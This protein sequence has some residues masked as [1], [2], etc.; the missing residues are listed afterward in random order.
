MDWFN[1][2]KIESLNK[3]IESLRNEL[4]ESKSNNKV[5]EFKIETLEKEIREK[6]EEI[7]EYTNE[8]DMLVVEKSNLTERISVQE[9]IIKGL[10]NEV[11]RTKEKFNELVELIN[12]YKEEM[13]SKLQEKATIETREQE[14]IIEKLNKDIRRR[15]EEVERLERKAST[16]EESYKN[17]REE[18]IRN[19]EEEN[20]RRERECE[21]KLNVLKEEI[22]ELEN[23]KQGFMLLQEIDMIDNPYNYE[24]SQEFQV[25]LD[26]IKKEQR[27]MVRDGLALVFSTTWTVANSK[28]KGEKMMKNLTKLALKSFNNECDNIIMNVRYSSMTTAQAK[29]EKSF[30]DTNKFIEVMDSK[31][32]DEY[33]ES[34]IKELQLKCGWLEKKEEEKEELRRQNE[35]L[36]E[37]EKL[38][39]EIALEEEKIEVEQQHFNNEIAN[40]EKQLES[41]NGNEDKLRKEIERLQAKIVELEERKATVLDRKMH[42]KA[43]YVYIISNPSLDGMYKIGTTRRLDPQIRV[44]ELG[45]ASLPFKF[46]VHSFIFSED[47]FGLE[48]ALH[49]A[50]ENKRVNKVNLHKEFFTATLEEIKEEVFRHNPNAEF[51]DEVVVEDYI[52]SMEM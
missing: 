35:I 3:E 17:R 42:N 2:E 23:R 46:G 41:K 7:N 40:L 31:I 14:D 1:K 37:Q 9:D 4:L 44:D 18:I 39:R 34:K 16:L 30:R 43:G 38:E 11:R 20:D 27:E 25:E 48:H 19:I 50:F 45:N 5:S 26:I 28:T 47:A 51:I 13:E 24:T 21:R 10:Q 36:K 12:E 29:I 8:L 49:M 33:L 6:Q 32:T 15:Q 52:L 22:E